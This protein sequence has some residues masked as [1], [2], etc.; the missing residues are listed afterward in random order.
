MCVTS[1]IQQLLYGHNF[2]FAKE[3]GSMQ[4]DFSF[5]MPHLILCVRLHTFVQKAVMMKKDLNFIARICLLNPLILLKKSS[6]FH[7][8]K[9]FA[10]S[11]A[12]KS[13]NRI[14]FF[15]THFKNIWCLSSSTMFDVFIWLCSKF[16]FEVYIYIYTTQQILSILYKQTNL[17]I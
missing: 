6:D 4:F 14:I 15:V 12:L 11:Y 7:I 3:L 17:N 2:F 16:R 1:T 5:H 10:T 9:I 13:L 8:N